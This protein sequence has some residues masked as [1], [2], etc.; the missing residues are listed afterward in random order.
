MAAELSLLPPTASV[1]SE[2]VGDPIRW[3]KALKRKYWFG[4]SFSDM[5]GQ[6][7]SLLL[8][9]CYAEETDQPF[10]NEHV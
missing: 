8:C 6:L 10:Y 7:S 3:L 9:K 5:H 4:Q 2:P 1:S